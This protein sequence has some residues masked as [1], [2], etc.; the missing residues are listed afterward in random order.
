MKCQL[1]AHNEDH[2]PAI[3]EDFQE[4]PRKQAG[5]L[6]VQEDLTDRANAS[7][8]PLLQNFSK[9]RHQPKLACLQDLF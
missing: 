7:P 5:E 8:F 2:V 1:D 6:V 3:W 4:T 9:T